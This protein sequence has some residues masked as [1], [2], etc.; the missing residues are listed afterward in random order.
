MD[1]R[2]EN[3]SSACFC[4]LA[5]G[6][7]HSLHYTHADNR[8]GGNPRLNFPASGCLCYRQDRMGRRTRFRVKTASRFCFT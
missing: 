6:C 2:L 3:V 4:V 1:G 5:A 8:V 7:S